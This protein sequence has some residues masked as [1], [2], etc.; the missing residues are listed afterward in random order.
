MLKI[1]LRDISVCSDLWMDYVVLCFVLLSV[2]HYKNVDWSKNS[3]VSN[4]TKYFINL[5]KYI[6]K[7]F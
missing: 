6:T 5:R 4:L 7:S 1:Y 2:N 3:L